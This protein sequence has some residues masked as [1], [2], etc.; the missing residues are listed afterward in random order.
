MG[1]AA[2]PL[3]VSAEQRDEPERPMRTHSTRQRIARRARMIL[4]SAEGLKVGR[5]A[6]QLAAWRKTVS[7]WRSRWRSSPGAPATVRERLSDAPRPG[8]P[9]RITPERTGKDY[10]GADLCHHRLGL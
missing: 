8:A 7:Q 2:P 5:I 4:L 9:A 6:E 10:P 1:R 3:D